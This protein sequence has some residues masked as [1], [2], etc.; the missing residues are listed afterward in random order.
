MS[1]LEWEVVPK[2]N[3]V[4]NSGKAKPISHVQ[5]MTP[6]GLLPAWGMTLQMSHNFFDWQ[7]PHNKM[8]NSYLRRW[9]SGENARNTRHTVRTQ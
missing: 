9:L 2:V 5:L 3:R 6:P 7:F 4:W 8:G 1:G